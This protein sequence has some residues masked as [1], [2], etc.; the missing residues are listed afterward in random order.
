M[1][2][3]FT[4][5]AVEFAYDLVRV[6][7]GYTCRPGTVIGTPSDGFTTQRRYFS[8]G[9]VLTVEMITDG[10]IEFAGFQATYRSTG[11][12]GTPTPPPAVTTPTSFTP[13]LTTA[14]PPT[15]ATTTI[16][17]TTPTTTPTVPTNATLPTSIIDTCST[18]NS[19]V[20]VL[21]SEL[22]QEASV[23][24]QKAVA[25][26][27]AGFLEGRVVG[28]L[29][30]YPAENCRQV[31]QF[32]AATTRKLTSG[33]Y[34]VRTSNGSAVQMYCDLETPQCACQTTT[35]GWMRVADIDMRDP[36]QNCPRGLKL[37]DTPLRSCGRLSRN[38]GCSSTFLST[39]GIPYSRVCGKVI[40]YQYSSPNAFY[41]HQY[42][43]EVTLEQYYVDGVSLT[44]GMSPRKHIW[45]FAA[46]RSEVD[47]SGHICPCINSGNT[48]PNTA[49]PEF[50]ENNY[51]CDTGSSE[52]YEN[53]RFYSDN[54][55]WDGNGCGPT[56]SC[57]DK[58][59]TGYFCRDLGAVTTD[60]IELRVC[61]NENTEN[62][63]V[64][65]EIVNVY[66]Q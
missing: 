27:L 22:L 35:P 7:E 12:A 63:D 34:W 8:R 9:E 44:Y 45:T 65:I 43:P 1:Q 23:I 32:R 4:S 57:C 19:Q 37:W 41:A 5:F 20:P 16:V 66:V 55:L 62:E 26:S 18:D 15:T 50:I 60:D 2:L 59:G 10:L 52:R 46:A 13:P 54:P 38:P 42:D 14:S 29:P 11:V 49:V 30:D 33:M 24:I 64:P 17:I 31:A 39:N 61:A 6:C 25:A 40:G 47:V 21:L 51:F 58:L 3:D 53:N 48:L 56:N 36:N 28:L